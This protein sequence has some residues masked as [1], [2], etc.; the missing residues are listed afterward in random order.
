MANPRCI[1][2]LP[3]NLKD[4]TV[5]VLEIAGFEPLR[6]H[7]LEFVEKVAE[8]LAQS[9]STW[10]EILGGKPVEEVFTFAHADK[11][12]SW[13]RTGLYPLQGNNGIERIIIFLND[14]TAIKVNEIKLDKVNQEMESTRRM[15]I[16]ILNEN[17]LW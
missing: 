12:T 10:T 5:G 17:S 2:I 1:L 6:E 9:I 7:E 16:R 3:L 14:I 15:L 11:N 13:L 8:A 4:T